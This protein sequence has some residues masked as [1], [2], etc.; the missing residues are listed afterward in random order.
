MMCKYCD[1][2]YKVKD[3]DETNLIEGESKETHMEMFL[4]Q[5]I[6][7]ESYWFLHIM[8]YDK[9]T[10]EETSE[11]SIPVNN[12]PICGRL[13]NYTKAKTFDEITEREG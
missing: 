11:F 9:E 7:D 5:S 12:C 3:R 10:N 1:P 2:T 8:K 4:T 6:D 13:L